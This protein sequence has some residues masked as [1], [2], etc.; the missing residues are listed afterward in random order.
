MSVATT[1]PT[2]PEGDKLSVGGVLRQISRGELGV[3][4]VLIGIAVIW[5]I[6]QLA[7][8]RF[9]SAVNLS[10]LSLQIAATAT[11][12]IGVVLVLL[13]GEIDLSVGAVSG[14]AAG[15]MAV[16]SVKEGLDP[17]LA[18]VAGLLVGT[19]IGLFNGLMVTTF[20]IP[21]FVVTLG[22]LGFLQGFAASAI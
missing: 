1:T 11:I 3:V 17:G 2:E 6:F 12:S 18:I 15:V 20:G 21:S 8:D 4:R 22:M 13:L 9:L 16:L 10:N 5:T 14:L 19:A 7:N